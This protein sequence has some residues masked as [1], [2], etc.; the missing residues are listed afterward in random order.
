MNKITREKSEN[1]VTISNGFLRDKNLSLK[2]KGFLAVIMGLPNN[3]DFSISGICTIL[4]EGKTA[5]YSAIQELKEYGYCKVEQCRDDCKIIGN[6]YTFYEESVLQ[7]QKEDEQDLENLNVGDKPQLNIDDKEVKKEEKENLQKKDIYTEIVDF[8][9]DNTDKEDFPR[10]SKVSSKIKSA[11]NARIK[12]GY[13]VQ[14]IKNAILLMNT[15]S[16]WYKGK[17][18]STWKATLLWLLKDTN[19]NFA[20]ILEG[21]LHTTQ[22]QQQQFNDIMRN[23]GAIDPN[24]YRPATGGYINFSQSQGMYWTHISPEFGQILD[25]Y[26]DDTRP[27]GAVLGSPFGVFKWSAAKRCWDCENND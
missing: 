19:G 27:D 16:D 22:L 26:K 21:G 15:L 13:T 7:C 18:N 1:Y 17:G 5:V 6:D 24:E 3:W 2:A 12:E 10:T 8:F 14:D 11:I 20:K 4:Q 9:N 25:G 23:N